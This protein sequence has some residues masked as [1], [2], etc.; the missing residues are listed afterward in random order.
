MDSL[1]IEGT[2][3]ITNLSPNYQSNITLEKKL[4]GGKVTWPDGTFATRDYVRTSTWVRAANPVA[5]EFH[6]DGS[7]D[8]LR[9][10]G[11]TYSADIM[12]TLIWKRR[13][14]RQGIRIPAEGTTLIQRS[15]K[16]DLSI[17]F[18]NGVCDYLI[19]ITIN[20]K[21]KTVDVRNL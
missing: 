13:C 12:D 16:P 5:D 17:D 20:N 6:V 9:R 8:A 18:G 19:T 3:S 1:A 21:S 14:L 2:R 11:S 10:D 4:T 7:A 15:G